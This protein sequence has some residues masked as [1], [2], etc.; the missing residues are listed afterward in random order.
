MMR[1]EVMRIVNI[2]DGCQE[3]IGVPAEHAE[4]GRR[5]KAAE[6]KLFPLAM[7]DADRYQW[8]VTLVGLLSADLGGSC[9]GWDDLAAAGPRLREALPALAVT[10]GVPLAALDP[11]LVVDAALAQQLRRLLAESARRRREQLVRSAREAGQDWVVLEEP[12]PAALAHGAAQWVEAHTRTGALLVRSV[13]PD[14]RTGEPVY[15]LQLSGA[16]PAGLEQE[17]SDSA[18]WMAGLDAVRRSV[19]SDS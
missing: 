4:L 7:V 17:H 1:C 5:L 3:P 11:D 14:L 6:D 10:A 12:D 19:E 8:A 2:S 15:R 9:Q 18:S 16:G 13:A